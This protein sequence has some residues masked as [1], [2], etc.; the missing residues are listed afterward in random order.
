MTRSFHYRLRKG[1]KPL[2]KRRKDGAG[3]RKR[4]LGGG[5]RTVG[6][7]KRRRDAARGVANRLLC[8]GG[9]GK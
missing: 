7:E 1:K 3:E 8:R 4:K 5:K 2:W 9:E 6:G